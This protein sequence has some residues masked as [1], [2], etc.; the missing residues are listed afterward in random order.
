ML[1]KNEI[2]KVLK[3]N[4]LKSDTNIMIHSSLK[5]IG[6]IEGRALGL[7]DTLKDYFKNGLIMF[8]MHTWSFIN[9][10]NDT[11][12]LLDENSCVGVLPNIAYRSGFIRSPHPTHSIIAYGKNANEYIKNDLNSSTPVN[13][14]GCFG[15]LHEIDAKVLF[16]GCNLSK[17]TYI[18]SI[19]ER[20]NVEDRFT[21]HIFNFY[22]KDN[23]NTYQF[24]MP[25]HYS[26]LNP[27]ISENYQ[28]LYLPLKEK[29]ILKEFML[30]NAK[31]MLVDT[32]QCY[33]FVNKLLEINNHIFDDSLEIDKSLYK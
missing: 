9:N 1:T 32:K 2:I 15:R 3:D 14:N 24:K 23:I 25:K 19:E 16:I 12:D 13:P 17:F 8:P 26:T 29:G 33:Q 22:S 6:E 5:S 11:L 7:I 4:G 28:K 10:D 18:H 30:G 20:H 27:H 21:S 31:C